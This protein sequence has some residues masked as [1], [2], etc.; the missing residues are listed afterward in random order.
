LELVRQLVV[1]VLECNEFSILEAVDANT[2]LA[3]SAAYPEKIDLLLA[4]VTLP[5]MS[6]VELAAVLTCDRPE[7]RVVIMS[8]CARESLGG[9]FSFIQ[10]PFTAEGLLHHIT[11]VSTWRELK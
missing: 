5:G 10:K 6:G 1:S 4:D 7:M 11:E 3:I 9:N 8:G 2:A